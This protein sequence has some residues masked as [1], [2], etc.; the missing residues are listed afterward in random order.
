MRFLKQ[1]NL[2]RRA[3]TG[4][5]VSANTATGQVTLGST[6]NVIVPTGTT[7]QRPANP[8]NGMVRYNTDI[9]A[10]GQ[11]E[12]YQS[13][14][15]RS[16]RF[17][18]SGTIVQQNL[19]VGDS[20]NTYFGPLST[21]Y[22]PSNVDS[23]NSTFGG[24]NIIVVVENVIQISGTNY[25]VVQNPT[26][27]AETYTAYT[28]ASTVV[29]QQ[30][31]YFNGSINAS[32]AAAAGTT[33]TVTFPSQSN[34]TPFAA[35]SS[36]IVTGFKPNA[37]NGTFTVT[38]STATTVVYTASSAPGASASVSG[39]VTSSNAIFPA[40]NIVGATVTGSANIQS[41]TLVSQ[42]TTDPYTGALTNIVL[43]K[44]TVTGAIA[45]NTAITIT[46]SARTISD[47]SYWLLF[48]SPVP[49]GKIV[50]VLLGF[51]Q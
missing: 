6:N 1:V 8:V 23:T 35:G 24:Q 51:D 31:L 5:D 2:N 12:I 33:V 50:T 25:T 19:G 26:V 16:L 27:K 42:Y 43:S 9:T 29:T 3:V 15:W 41:S 4:F 47:S 32:S 46:E 14:K 10:G 48:S 20:D 11:L 22:N 38:S 40:V 37:Y 30:I 36:I 13:S 44:P 28:N 39:N 21:A 34:P 17:K 18:E 45:A 49:Y 7:A